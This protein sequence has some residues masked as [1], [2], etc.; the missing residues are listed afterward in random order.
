MITVYLSNIAETADSL[1]QT[2]ESELR[3]PL[4]GFMKTK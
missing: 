4:N 3:Y 2:L 1:N